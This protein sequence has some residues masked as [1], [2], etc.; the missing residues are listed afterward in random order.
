MGELL[1]G[2][3]R[4]EHGV[5]VGMAVETARGYFIEVLKMKFNI[6]RNRTALVP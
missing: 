5:V 3:Q 6:I 4:A 2:Q 1:V